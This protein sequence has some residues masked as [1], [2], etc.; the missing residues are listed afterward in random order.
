M[1]WFADANKLDG[2]R[3][4]LPVPEGESPLD[5]FVVPSRV[6]EGDF[7]GWLRDSMA[8]RRVSARMLAMRAGIDH[9]TIS[10][11]TSGSREPTLRTALALLRVLISEPIQFQ[12]APVEDEELALEVG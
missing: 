8:A 11:L 12:I 7:A 3:C 4:S 10:R 5:S 1:R 9:S 2:P 6:W